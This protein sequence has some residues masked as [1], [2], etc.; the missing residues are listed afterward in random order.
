[1]VGVMQETWISMTEAVRLSGLASRTL[2]RYTQEGKLD[3][4][5]APSGRRIFRKD[6]IL[7]LRH[8]KSSPG[9]GGVVVYARVSSRRQQVEG[10]LDRQEQRLKDHAGDRLA[11]SFRDVASGLSDRRPGLR[12]ALTAVTRGPA[13]TLVVTHRD[14]LARFGTRVIEHQLS[15]VGV[16]VVYLDDGDATGDLQAE[17]VADL[18]AIVTSFAGRLYG[19]RSAKAAQLRQGVTAVTGEPDDGG[20][21]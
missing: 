19:Q 3:D 16:S 6:D 2:R 10:D 5:R 20:V 15:L 14:R 18:V 11:G 1:M 4:V 8:P 21:Q 9:A 12:S 13:T 17:M 7:A